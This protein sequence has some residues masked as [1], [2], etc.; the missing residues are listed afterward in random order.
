MPVSW[1][2]FSFNCDLRLSD[3]TVGVV[4]P[5]HSTRRRSW[6]RH[7]ATSRVRFPIISL[8]L[9][10][11]MKLG[12]ALGSTQTLTEMNTRNVPCRVKAAGA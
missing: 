4:V 8:E 6:L 7:C 11:D 2:R 5:L 12:A 9:F 1:A 10:I 3:S